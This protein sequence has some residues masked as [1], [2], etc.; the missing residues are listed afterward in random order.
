VA[1]LSQDFRTARISTDRKLEK[2]EKEQETK[3]VIAEYKLQKQ[4]TTNV[5]WCNNGI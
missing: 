1:K 3:S 2:E 4:G 5:I